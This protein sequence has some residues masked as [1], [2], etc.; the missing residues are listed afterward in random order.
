MIRVI[1]LS[2]LHMHKSRHKLDNRNAATLVQHLLRRFKGAP[3]S[4]TYVVLTG[5]CVDD[6]VGR[7]YGQL[8]RN[9]L[10]PLAERFSV[11]AAPGNHDY[12]FVGNLFDKKAPERF[13]RYVG[14]YVSGVTYPCRTPNHAERVLFI[15]L[16]SADPGD[17]RWFAEGV[18][19]KDQRDALRKIL[20]DDKYDEYFKI[21]YL[22]H[23]PF[24][25]DVGVALSD[26][27]ELLELVAE[28]VD[29]VLFGHKHKGEA[30]FGR[31]RVPLMLASG[32]VTEAKGEAL[33]FRVV[34]IDDGKLVGLHTE[35]IPSADSTPIYA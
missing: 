31:F 12:A 25:R 20:E 11:L 7:Q 33:V 19:G 4:K 35:E 17:Q 21:A 13:R 6:A 9:V 1:H 23:H 18:I 2:D 14:P 27:E 32:K 30:F 22:H 29:L 16:D 28:R 26:Y 8:G 34:E 10:A 3:K 24:F 5:D 15:G